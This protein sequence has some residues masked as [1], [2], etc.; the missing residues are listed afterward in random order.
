M[1]ERY[2]RRHIFCCTNQRPDGHPRGCCGSERGLAIRARFQQRI[3]GEGI[4]HTRASK[5]LCLDRCEH[6]PCVVIYPDAVW[7]RIEDV[8]RDVDE[9]SDELPHASATA[10]VARWTGPPSGTP[11]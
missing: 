5:S 4:A 11:L 8:E 6:G 9:I 10:H 1:T 3:K 2:Y 7:Y